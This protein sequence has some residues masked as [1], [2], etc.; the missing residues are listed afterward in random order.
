MKLIAS[1]TALIRYL[2]QE[3]PEN[4]AEPWDFVGYSIKTKNGAKPLKILTCL[5]VDSQVVRQAIANDVSLILSFH[6]FCFAP[7]W[8]T[9]YAYDPLKKTLVQKLKK[10]QIN[11]YSLHTNFD[12]HPQGTKYWLMQ[13]LGWQ[14]QINQTFTYAYLINLKQSLQ[15][16]VTHLKTQLKI[17]FV[18]TN[19]Q[20]NDLIDQVYLAPGASDVYQFLE[21][22]NDP[23]VTLITSD[24]KW[25]EQQLLHDLGYKF[26]LI[27]HQ[28]EAVFNQGI[29]SFLKARLDPAIKI[30]NYETVDFLRG[31]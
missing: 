30:L 17:N 13:K 2:K 25:N 29:T 23:N 11:V 10:A 14:K 4:W 3:F 19:C 7:D 31:Y 22:I 1:E 20:A 9:V 16:L 8:K 24:V 28:T 12:R 27:S 18:I 21:T 6:P 26:I 5:D 15:D